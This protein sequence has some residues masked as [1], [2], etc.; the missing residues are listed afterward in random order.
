MARK[1]Y[2]P[3]E[4]DAILAWAQH[5]EGKVSAEGTSV[6]MTTEQ[7]AAA[8][9]ALGRI[10]TAITAATTARRASLDA[11]SAKRA[12]IKKELEAV[13][14]L[15]ARVKTSGA[16]TEALGLDWGIVGP[17]SGFDPHTYTPVLEAHVHPGHVEIRFQ[18]LGVD[19]LNI[20]ARPRGTE[21]WTKLAY[22][23][24]SPY[25]DNRPATGAEVREYAAIGVVDDEEVGLM[26]AI[27][28]VTVSA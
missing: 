22:D 19:G 16:Y 28:E 9:G 7:I 23:T 14:P 11:T 15:M 27:V 8:R 24:Q 21:A 13:R 1:D 20:Y 6:E 5:L 12:A 17:E 2:V 10:R 18:K 25:I 3:G 4:D 26:S